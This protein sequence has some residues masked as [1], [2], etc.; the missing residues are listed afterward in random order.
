MS[1]IFITLI[2]GAAVLLSWPLGRAMT[3]AMNPGGKVGGFRNGVESLFQKAAGQAISQGADLEGV[4]L[5]HALLQRIHV[6]RRA[7]RFCRCSRLFLSIRM[8]RAR[9]RTQPDFPYG[10]VIHIEHEPSALF[11]RGVAELLFADFRFDVAAIR[12]RRHRN[13]RLD[14]SCQ[15]ACGQNHSRKL[16]SR[17]HEGDLSRVAAAGSCGGGAASAG[18]CS[19]DLAGFGHGQ[20][21]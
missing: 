8:A 21:A 16:L 6:H 9:L 14:R 17:P 18:R 7:M 10:C 4:C 12:F 3:W 1:I 2:L 20:N 5:V 19:H 13:S 11:R 15:G